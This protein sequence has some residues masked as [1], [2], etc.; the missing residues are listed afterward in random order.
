MTLRLQR[1]LHL[2][3]RDQPPALATAHEV[4]PADGFG[5]HL[6]ECP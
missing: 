6:V 2:E 1:T 4:K 3:L 5:E